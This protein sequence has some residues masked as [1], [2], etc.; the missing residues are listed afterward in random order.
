MFFLFWGK[1]ACCLVGWL[2]AWTIVDW[3]LPVLIKQANNPMVKRPN[4]ATFSFPNESRTNPERCSND[5]RAKVE[6]RSNVDLS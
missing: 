3:L 4:F 5:V 2:I 1:A 6:R